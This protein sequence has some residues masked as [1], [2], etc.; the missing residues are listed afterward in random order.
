VNE[1]LSPSERSSLESEKKE[2][3]VTLA[4]MEESGAGTTAERMDKDKIQA[5]IKR[6]DLA[7]EERTPAKVGSNDKDKLVKEEKELEEKIAE[8]M[9]T[10]FE[11]RK[12]SMNP[13][14]IRKHMRWCERNVKRIERYRTIQ[15]MLR[16]FEPKSIEN[17][18]KEK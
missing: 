16:P 15:R 3:E 8:G 13:G 7:I 10:W 9:P 11:M 12:P 6:M 4:A 5:E 14:A 2:L 17:L 18:R 1:Y